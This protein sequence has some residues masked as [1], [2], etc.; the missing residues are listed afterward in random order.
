MSKSDRVFFIVVREGD[1]GPVISTIAAHTWY[2]AREHARRLNGVR[3]VN[4]S[5]QVEG[6]DPADADV[7]VGDGD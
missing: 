1:D 6:A 4:V 7:R 2:E 3:L 5:A